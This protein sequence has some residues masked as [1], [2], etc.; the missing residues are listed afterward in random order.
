MGTM[1]IYVCF[2]VFGA[3]LF[4]SRS[5]RFKTVEATATTLFAVMNGDE[6]RDTFMDLIYVMNGYVQTSPSTQVVHSNV[7]QKKAL[8]GFY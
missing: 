5:S 4:G 7:I 8:S 1:P 6:M 2:F 3:A